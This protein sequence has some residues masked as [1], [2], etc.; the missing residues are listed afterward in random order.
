MTQDTQS[1]FAAILAAAQSKANDQSKPNF[2]PIPEKKPEVIPDN[3]QPV[4]PS[5]MVSFT[6]IWQEGSG[7]FDGKIF[8]TWQTANNAMTSIYNEHSGLGYLKVKICVKWENG[9]EITDRADCSDSSGDFCAKRETIGQHL[10]RY[11]SVM[12]ASNLNKGDRANLSFEDEYLDLQGLQKATITE[13]LASPNFIND[14][15]QDSP[16]LSK[17]T[18]E[19][20]I[21]GCEPAEDEPQPEATATPTPTFKIV[22]YSDRSFAIITETK[23]PEDVLNIFRL[24]GSYN[25][26]LKCGKGWI[27]SKRHLDT[28][29]A[30]LNIV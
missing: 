13:F 1:K 15:A 17:Y 19:D 21:T 4:K 7:K 5:K 26:H 3:S 2:A 22:D 11:N 23:P 25:A 29:K 9:A 27:F 8:T 14:A 18:I 28:V 16:E 30:K 6:I 20:I 10:S 12:Y 24:H